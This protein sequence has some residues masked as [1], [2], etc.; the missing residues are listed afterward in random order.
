MSEFEDNLWLAV[1]R[2]HGDDLARVGGAVPLRRR[3]IRRQL[4]A[5][6]TV[7]VAAMATAAAVLLG[8]STSQPAFAVTRNPDG[9]VTVKLTK[10]SGIA[11]VNAKLAAMGVRAQVAA[12][13][14][15]APR[16]VCPGGTAPAITFDPASVPKGRV[17][18]ITPGQP[19]ADKAPALG[20]K[21]TSNNTSVA[22]HV[23]R[24]YSGGG[25]IRTY[26][27]TGNH[28]VRMY[29]P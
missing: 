20:P 23:V 8:A 15:Q 24:T 1:V 19:G 25:R 29:C 4:L 28:V 9:T 12:L 7:G 14:K 17:L 26:S 21:P 11:G 27:G 6:T 10:A 13:T 18:M 16:L 5:G 2:E 22:N 3:P